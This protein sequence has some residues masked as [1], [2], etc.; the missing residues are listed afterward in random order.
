STPSMGRNKKKTTPEKKTPPEKKTKTSEK[1]KTSS[2]GRKKENKYEE[3]VPKKKKFYMDMPQDAGKFANAQS[4]IISFRVRSRI[5][6]LELENEEKQKRDLE[7]EAARALQKVFSYSHMVK[8][9]LWKELYYDWLEP[10]PPFQ[11]GLIPRSLEQIFQTSQAL[12]AQGWKYKMQACVLEIYNENIQYLLASKERRKQQP[13]YKIMAGTTS[14]NEQSSR[15]H[16]VF[17]LR[18]DGVNESAE[19]QVQGVLNLIDLAGSERLS[20]SEATGE[21]L[22]ETQAINKSLSALGEVIYV[23]SNKGDHIPFRNSKLTLLLLQVYA[24]AS[25]KVGPPMS[26]S[27]PPCSISNGS[28]SQAED[29]TGCGAYPTD[30]TVLTTSDW[31]ECSFWLATLKRMIKIRQTAR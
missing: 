13:E 14:M 18:I 19:Q 16:F 11:K 30:E 25:F 3:T 4:Y 27:L 5:G 1:K 22:K 31:D 10:N 6:K 29:V 8:P 17:I 24:N 21:R 20:R 7:R 12:A 15:S 26:S 2:R 23:L 9:F 28:H